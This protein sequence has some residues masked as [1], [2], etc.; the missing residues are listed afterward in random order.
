MTTYS[1]HAQR[2]LDQHDMDAVDRHAQRVMR[3]MEQQSAAQELR[4]YQLKQ[5]ADQEGEIFVVFFG[6]HQACA[7][8]G[9]C[10]EDDAKECAGDTNF[11]D[12]PDAS[13]TGCVV[14]EPSGRWHIAH[15]F[16]G[17]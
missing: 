5:C 13:Y 9:P 12:T 3:H 14:L 6:R 16:N 15:L 8:G 17:E 11:P 7:F 4:A 10:A 2:L 1:E